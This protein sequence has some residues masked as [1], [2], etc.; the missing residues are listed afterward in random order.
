MQNHPSIRDESKIVRALKRRRVR[1]VL[2][3]FFLGPLGLF[4]TDPFGGFVTSAAALIT[5]L[6]A[7]IAGMILLWIACMVWAVVSVNKS[8]SRFKS[9]VAY[10]WGGY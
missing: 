2:M 10:Y 6:I 9:T 7:P 4:Y 1:A 5:L 3:A 8:Y